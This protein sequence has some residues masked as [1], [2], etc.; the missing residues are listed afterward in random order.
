[1]YDKTL[2]KDAHG[3]HYTILKYVSPQIQAQLSPK[4]FL[5]QQHA[6]R[7]LQDLDVPTGYWQGLLSEVSSYASPIMNEFELEGAVSE[8]I[9]SGQLKVFAVSL[10]ASDSSPEKRTI[11]T[12]EAHYAFIKPE[13]QLL[14]DGEALHFQNEAE[15]QALEMRPYV[16]QAQLAAADVLEAAGRAG[17]AGA[18]RTQAREVIGE[19]G[20]LLEDENLRQAYLKSMAKVTA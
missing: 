6:H 7:F 2:V 8:V 16:W 13:A 15:A 3:R 1:M 10:P 14:S 11:T 18:K 5:D 9:A 17:D 19:I 12:S 4:E 20:G